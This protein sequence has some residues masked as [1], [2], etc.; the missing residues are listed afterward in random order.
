MSII[1]V[2]IKEIILESGKTIDLTSVSKAE[3]IEMVKKSYGFLSS[4]LD[5]VIKGETVIVNFPD[6][7]A[8]K[9]EEAIG[10]YEK[11][12]KKAERGEYESAISLFKKTIGSL[13]A[14][15][16]ARRNLA[17][18]YLE[19][20]NIEE[21]KNQL[22]DVLRLNQKDAWGYLL[23]GNVYSKHE[24]DFESAEPFYKKAFELNPN[25]PY[26]LTNYATLRLEKGDKE[27]AK[28]LF[29]RAINAN[30][31][32]PN[33]YLGLAMLHRKEMKDKEALRI[34]D[35]M[36]ESPRST[37]R[38]SESVYEHSRELYSE[39]C[40]SIA[41]N[42]FDEMM[43]LVRS[44]KLALEHG[45]GVRIDIVEDNSLEMVSA[46]TQMA[47]KHGR[48][49]H[50][51]SYRKVES[52]VTPHLIAHELEHISLESEARIGNQNK[53]F[54][55]TKENR[56]AAI[57]SISEDVQRLRASGYGG[58]QITSVVL[59]LVGGLTN[60]LFNCPLDMMIE[61][62]LAAKYPTL[63]PTQF[64]SLLKTQQ[65][66]LT[67]LT[68]NEI[69]RLTPRKIYQAN[70]AM[71]CA[72]ALF[73]D[74]LYPSKTEYHKPY[75]S[76]SQYEVGKKLFE[77]FQRTNKSFTPGKEYDLVQ[78]FSK[79]LKLEEWYDLKPDFVDQE[80]STRQG[81]T[82]PHL[83]KTLEPA[84]I[85]HCLGAIERFEPMS[86]EEIKG[87]SFEIGLLGVHGI[88]YSKSET[89]YS[90][91]SIPG[92]QF[93]GLQ[94]LSLMYV[95]FK[96]IDPTLDAGVDFQNAYDIALQMHKKD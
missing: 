57:R 23:L 47:W 19:L 32:Y 88:D 59:K 84:I 94:L 86:S 46:R 87:V 30:N 37:D 65:E 25:D 38:R 14:H 16:D 77:A 67:I 83:L 50:N 66:N 22:I 64:Y 91:K 8:K 15:T 85:M 5:V 81:P 54:F 93:S 79:I 31:E 21:A 95:G 40:R 61:S 12:V 53:I 7:K 41:Q 2:S 60:Q 58:D 82:N 51:I 35:E 10:F 20:G 90:L 9:V 73:T 76:S 4:E 17:M 89:R 36:F 34:L 42:S 13:P 52:A 69:K 49:F 18:S 29:I 11:G 28:D 26:L 80:S 56:E 72:Y 55:S 45:G 6:E 39:T 68:N 63:M 96:K 71:N 33:A 43:N 44:A 24:N 75:K 70:L 78:D 62:R 74:W 3:V 27:A 1:A 48:N 92:E